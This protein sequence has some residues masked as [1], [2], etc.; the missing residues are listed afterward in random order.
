MDPFYR[1][2]EL[3]KPVSDYFTTRGYTVVQEVNI[4]YC[5]AD[6][7]AFKNAAVTA[8]EL[9][10]HDRK[11]AVVQAKNYQLG[12]D[13]VYLAFPLFNSYSLLRKSESVLIKEGIG[14]LVVD[15]CTCEVRKIIEAAPSAR[16]FTTMTLAEV[17]KQRMKRQSMMRFY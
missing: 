17:Q 5:R 6:L 15:E 4:G 14:L 2:F 16:K 9:K 12:A 13:Y 1:E 10:L 11:K 3:L 7:V 8:I